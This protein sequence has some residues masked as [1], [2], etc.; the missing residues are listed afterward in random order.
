S[1]SL[2]SRGW[3]R[4][5]KNIWVPPLLIAVALVL[6]VAILPLILNTLIGIPFVAKLLVSGAILVPLGFVMGTPFPTGLRVLASPM[7]RVG[8]GA[9]DNAI[10]WAWAMN[11]SASVLGSVLAIVIAIQFGLNATLACGALAYGSALLL[12]RTL[13]RA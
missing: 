11:A 9:N 1:G 6:Y 8:E 7:A 4:D 5:T 10:E 12:T 2:L 13:H 3:L